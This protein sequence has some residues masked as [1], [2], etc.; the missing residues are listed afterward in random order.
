[1]QRKKKKRRKRKRLESDFLWVLIDFSLTVWRL[2]GEAKFWVQDK[3]I[4]DRVKS[5]KILSFVL[6]S[7]ECHK[8]NLCS[9]GVLEPSL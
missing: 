2:Y 9:I 1:M 6:F 4:M 5:K 7:S 3:I 8:D